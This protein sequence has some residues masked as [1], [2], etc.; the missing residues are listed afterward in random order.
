MRI[1]AVSSQP[2]ARFIDWGLGSPWDLK[3]LLTFMLNFSS[4][5]RR[6]TKFAHGH[7]FETGCQN[8]DL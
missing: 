1:R 8:H 2:N 6:R 5:L 4:P 3:W 7:L